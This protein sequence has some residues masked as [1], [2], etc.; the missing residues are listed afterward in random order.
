MFEILYE[1]LSTLWE[2]DKA[3]FARDKILEWLFRPMLFG[4]LNRVVVYAQ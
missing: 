1:S 2:S 4:F 3:I